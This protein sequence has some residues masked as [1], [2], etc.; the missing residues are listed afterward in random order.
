MSE[1]RSL[2][3]AIMVGRRTLEVDQ[4]P[5]GLPFQSLR[6]RRVAE[7]RPAFPLRVVV[8]RSGRLSPDSR[9]L[10]EEGGER[11]LFTTEAMAPSMREALSTKA[12]VHCAEKMD[13][14][15]ILEILHDHYGVKTVVCEGGATLFRSLL[16]VDCVDEIYVTLHPRIFGGGKAPTLTGIPDGFL[17]KSVALKLENME[18]IEEECFLHYTVKHRHPKSA[19]NK[20]NRA[21]HEQ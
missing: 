2:A 15:H 18:V 8:T 5:M 1:I 13:L 14:P 11:I 10:Q 4:M 16:E 7:G 20:L 3:D 19:S 6:A 12:Q 21:R 17:G 9:M